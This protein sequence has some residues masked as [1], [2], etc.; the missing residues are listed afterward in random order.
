MRC[1]IN[2]AEINNTIVELENGETTFVNCQKL[3]SLYVVK[4]HLE[5]DDV[6]EKYNDILPSYKDYCTTKAN[7][8]INHLPKE[9][10]IDAM[11][12]VCREIREFL[13]I[14]FCNT[15]MKEE[16]IAIKDCL[17]KVIEEIDSI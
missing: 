4:E 7:Y 6:I 5:T 2:I 3:A 16:R 15:D 13:F 11:S 8:Q 12:N 1:D 10:L 9:M 17:I 14:L